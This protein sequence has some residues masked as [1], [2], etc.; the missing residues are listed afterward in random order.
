MD[1]NFLRKMWRK[2]L[3]CDE[4]VVA[5]LEVIAL[6]NDGQTTRCECA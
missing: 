1:M 4:I 6:D 5:K 2:R 3:T